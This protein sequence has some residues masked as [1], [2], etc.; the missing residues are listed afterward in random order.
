MCGC[1]NVKEWVFIIFA[2]SLA[3][4]MVNILAAGNAS[5]KYIKFLCGTVCL[6]TVISPLKQLILSFEGITEAEISDDISLPDGNEYI[7]EKT[8][9]EIEEYIS[10]YLL[11]EG[12]ICTGISIEITVTDTETVIGDICVSVEEDDVP[13]AKSLLEGMAEVISDG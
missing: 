2:V 1:K 6:L 8:K 10:G 11:A 7:E 3:G 12:I 4:G 13:K 5:E 9:E